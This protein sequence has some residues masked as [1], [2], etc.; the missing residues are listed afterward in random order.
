MTLREIDPTA[1]VDAELEG[2][3]CAFNALWDDGG[4]AATGPHSGCCIGSHNADGLVR[5]TYRV[6][7]ARRAARI[8]P[9]SSE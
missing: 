8:T 4:G 2:D 5:G 7:G 6:D 9:S 3:A 1:Y